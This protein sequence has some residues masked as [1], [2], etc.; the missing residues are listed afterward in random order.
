MRDKK[1]QRAKRRHKRGRKL[2]FVLGASLAGIVAY[3]FDPQ[4]GRTRRAKARDMASS[5]VRR[6]AGDVRD[7]G[8]RAA[9]KA[10]GAAARMQPAG[11]DYNDPTLQHKVESEVLRD[12]PNGRVNVNAEDGRVVLRGELDTPDQI[13]TLE[14]RV[15]HMPG[16][17]EV[18]NLTHLRGSA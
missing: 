11:H 8:V 16:V 17:R 13:R 15:R 7:M 1:A 10:Q 9:N 18:E 4:L 12:F 6:G 2:S 3:F 5:R 14:D